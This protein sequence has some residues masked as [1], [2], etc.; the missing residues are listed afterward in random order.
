MKELISSIKNMGCYTIEFRNV[1]NQEYKGEQGLSHLFQHC[2]CESIKKYDKIFKRLGIKWNASTSGGGTVAFYMTGLVKY[3]RKYINDFTY[4]ILT[5]QIPKEIFERQRNIVIAEYK[6]YYIDQDERFNLNFERKHYGY[7]EAL[8]YLKDLQNITYEQFLNFKNKAMNCLNEVY[9]IHPKTKKV[10]QFEQRVLNILKLNPQ[11]FLQLDYKYEENNTEYPLQNYVEGEQKERILYF[12]H[13][14]NFQKFDKYKIQA[15]QQLMNSYL[16]GGLTSYLFKEIR[17]K[18]G[19]VYSIYQG[20]MKFKNQGYLIYAM[21]VDVNNVERVKKQFD[22]CMKKL[23]NHISK[24]EFIN[25]YK[26]IIIKKEI[27]NSLT[28]TDY[29]RYDPEIQNVQEYLT[30]RIITFEEFKEYLIYFIDT[31]KVWIDSDYK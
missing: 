31:Y 22:K 3:I 17:Q 7:T 28:Y 27:N 16:C 20:G 15:I 24:R 26:S 6:Q 12:G 10:F 4:N 21:N 25:C 8:G 5:Y 18:L 11:P 30:K 29:Y 1:K 23:K 13:L 14:Y 2:M 9:F 19:C